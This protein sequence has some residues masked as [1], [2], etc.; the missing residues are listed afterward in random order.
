ME[1]KQGYGI[2]ISSLLR[3]HSTKLEDAKAVKGMYVEG[4]RTGWWFRE[5]SMGLGTGSSPKDTKV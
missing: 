2:V 5:N 1:T 4:E 3:F